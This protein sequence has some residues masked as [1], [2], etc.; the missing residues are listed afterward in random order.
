[1]NS[2]VGDSKQKS[3]SDFDRKK[4][5]SILVN[6]KVIPL[7]VAEK[8]D[9]KLKEKN[10][11][12]TKEQLHTLVYKIRGIFENYVKTGK[13]IKQSKWELP[14]ENMQKLV[15]TID[16][17][18]KRI[19]IIEKEK[20]TSH[21]LVTTND[22]TIPFQELELDPLQEIPSDP[23]S[24]I[25]LMKWLQYLMDKCGREN[26][27]N[28]LDYYVDIGWISQD[29]KISLID[30][31]QGITEEKRSEASIKK[32]VSHL[33][34]KDHIQSL[35]YIH[36]LKGRQ[37]DRHFIERIDGELARITKKLDNYQFK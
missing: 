9:E 16:S 31:S 3:S 26:L 17:L 5:L 22:I 1:M 13:S 21:K 11:K 36:K 23:E 7:K 14:A 2:Q 18:E 37:F 10:V 6:Q 25:V 20:T 32:D 28:I 4:E 8:I 12:V 27:S 34:S 29:A 35:I 24:I 19:S 33:P 30:Y 15:E